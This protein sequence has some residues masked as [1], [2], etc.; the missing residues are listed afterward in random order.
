MEGHKDE[1][2]ERYE[3]EIRIGMLLLGVLAFAFV[4]VLA[5]RIWV[6]NGNAS[7]VIKKPVYLSKA[8]RD[9]IRGRVKPLPISS[10][11]A[12]AESKNHEPNKL[13]THQR[14]ESIA[15]A[16]AE[17]VPE[18]EITE[19]E[20]NGGESRP[21]N[22]EDQE[23]PTPVIKSPT[24]L[25][26]GAKKSPIDSKKTESESDE[27]EVEPAIETEPEPEIER[28]SK[29]NRFSEE[30]KVEPKQEQ[31]ADSVSPATNPLEST[32]PAEQT[33]E[34]PKSETAPESATTTRVRKK[35]DKN[36]WKPSA[37]APPKLLTRRYTVERGDTLKSIAKDLL[38]DE[39]RWRE[40]YDL[41]RSEIGDDF[42][43][44]PEGLRLKLP[45]YSDEPPHDADFRSKDSQ[46]PMPN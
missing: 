1:A 30:P 44:L 8:E 18:L 13:R 19:T 7:A 10:I 41:N 29:A 4:G 33:T 14:H 15:N 32:R 6:E 5:R 22:F 9:A 21:A 12:S 34:P 17:P 42:E 43:Y 28:P 35:V 31:K 2:K 38:S 40:I 46:V 36:P 23:K 37:A 39:T 20:S 45:A 27:E 24:S 3:R 11:Y 16:N 26:N 25:P